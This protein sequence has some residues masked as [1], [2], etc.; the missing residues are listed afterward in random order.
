MRFF[1][2]EGEKMEKLGIFSGNFTD[3]ELSELTQPKQHKK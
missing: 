1:C 3:P 2:P